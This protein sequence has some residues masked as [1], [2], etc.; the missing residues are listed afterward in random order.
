VNYIDPTGYM[1][2]PLVNTGCT[3]FSFASNLLLGNRVHK[4]VFQDFL[5]NGPGNRVD[6]KAD[7]TIGKL[8]GA[9]GAWVDWATGDP[10]LTDTLDELL[11]RPDLI[12][13]GTREVWEIKPMND[14]GQWAAEEEVRDYVD[15][16]NYYD[17]QQPM[18]RAGTSYSPPHAILV[19]GKVIRF[20]ASEPGVILY[21]PD[22]ALDRTNYGTELMTAVNVAIVGA[23]IIHSLIAAAAVR[24]LA[25]AL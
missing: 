6:R 25:G 20:D 4:A 22:S 12:Q 15:H 7:T 14:L 18:W 10:N 19:G 8:M 3:L 16:M 9:L 23:R 11:L 1:A 24:G 17:S 2:A 13:E 5:Q 21:C